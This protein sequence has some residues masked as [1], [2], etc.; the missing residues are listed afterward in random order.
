MRVC[1]RVCTRV[2]MR[3]CACRREDG[4]PEPPATRTHCPR[5]AGTAQPLR[6]EA[7][8]P[9]GGHGHGRPPPRPRSGGPRAPG[10]A[11]SP[12]A[13]AGGARLP[14]G[15]AGRREAGPGRR[16]AEL[17][18]HGRRLPRQRGAWKPP[19]RPSF[20]PGSR[21]A[22]KC[23]PGDR[24]T[25]PRIRSG[26]R[27]SG[28]QL[29]LG[30]WAEGRGGPQGEPSRASWAKGGRWALAASWGG[31]PGWTRGDCNSPPSPV[32]EKEALTGSERNSGE[33]EACTCPP[34]AAT[35]GSGLEK[36][37]MG[38]GQLR[39]HTWTISDFQRK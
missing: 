10:G 6:L 29:G 35:P 17:G 31:A 27:P 12:L 16:R 18:N 15:G 26:S 19:R 24:G 25:S 8:A 36:G 4:T 2:C 5:P 30:A 3:V 22:G 37:S 1:T 13:Q 21:H 32:R 38:E 11:A 14:G 34:W 39:Y 9:G 28:G 20:R 7:R 23:S 33:F